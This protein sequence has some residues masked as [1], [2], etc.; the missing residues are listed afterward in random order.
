MAVAGVAVSE[1]A[2]ALELA[3]FDLFR[4]AY[5]RWFGRQPDPDT[6]ERA[7]ADYMLRDVVPAWVRRL[8]AD[9]IAQRDTCGLSPQAMGAHRYRDRPSRPP[10]GALILGAFALVWAVLYA[11]LLDLE[12]D[13]E[14]VQGRLCTSGSA[15]LDAW[16]TLLAGGP[17]EAT[18]T[19]TSVT[20]LRD[21]PVQ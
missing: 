2:A 12:P 13:R 11:C 5:R 15:F 18:C 10:H 6:L 8:C 4:L 17:A 14:G 9:V 7:F 21:Q 16:A 3:E 19:E 1:A 20:G